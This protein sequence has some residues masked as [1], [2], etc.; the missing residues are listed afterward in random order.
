[1]TNTTT[2]LASLADKPAEEILKVFPE[3][4]AP[5]VIDGL[6]MTSDPQTL[7][8]TS[9]VA[10]PVDLMLGFNA[11]EGFGFLDLFHIQKSQCKSREVAEKAMALIVERDFYRALPRRARNLV[12]ELLRENYIRDCP[13]D[14]DSLA[15]A[16]S[17]CYG[18]ILFV[19]P[20]FHTAEQHSGN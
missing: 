20:T 18:D 9:A 3:P 11:D 13:D 12:I 10:C 6:Y 16:V 14:G 8:R 2:I 15:K 1:M 4:F 5:K 19:A 17:D 7:Y